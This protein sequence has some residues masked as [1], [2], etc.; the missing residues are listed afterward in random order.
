MQSGLSL[1]EETI[2]LADKQFREPLRENESLRRLVIR[3][4]R[5]T[6]SND[7]WHNYVKETVKFCRW[8]GKSPDELIKSEPQWATLLNDYLDELHSKGLAPSTLSMAIWGIKKWLAVNDV[9]DMKSRAWANVEV[10]KK[11]RVETDRLP[12][13][14]DLRKI[15]NA[16][17]ACDRVIVTLAVSSGLR[18]SSLFGLKLKDIDLSM[19]TPVIKPPAEETKGKVS[20]FTFCTPEAKAAIQTFLKSR[21]LNGEVL[22]PENYLIP[23][24]AHA[25]ARLTRVSAGAKWRKLL[26]Q[27]GVAEKGHRWYTMHF[28]TLR[29]FFKTYATLSGM[30]SDTVEY[31][32]GHRASLRQVYFVPDA[33][34]VAPEVLKMLEGEYAKAV[35]SLTVFN[36]EGKIKELERSIDE[37]GRD[38]KEKENL[39]DELKRKNEAVSARLDAIEKALANRSSQEAGGSQGQTNT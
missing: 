11:R 32:M 16:G 19:D 21:E 20:F 35:N 27:A 22:T 3:M 1:G 13:R 36:D 23:S 6:G 14:E 17:D 18:K 38:L 31:L 29:K 37:K 33:E 8:A 9:E 7:S 2:A 34:T 28:H 30:S 5:R 10:P 4:L 12:T 25:G 15:L 24:Q 39:I 26:R